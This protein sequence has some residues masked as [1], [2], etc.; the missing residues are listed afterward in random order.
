MAVFVS[1]NAIIATRLWVLR[2]DL[3]ARVLLASLVGL[4]FVALVSHAWADDTIAYL[5][6]GLAGISLAPAILTGKDKHNVS[7]KKT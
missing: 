1:L 3:L 6:W 5:W 2:E 4:S 7:T